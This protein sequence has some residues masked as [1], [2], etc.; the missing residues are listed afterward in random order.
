MYSH[1]HSPVVHRRHEPPAAATVDFLEE[2]AEP[3]VVATA[4][5]KLHGKKKW[6]N[7]RK[8]SKLDKWRRDKKWE[9]KTPKEVEPKYKN[10]RYRATVT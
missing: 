3:V 10:N 5:R 2:D 9:G 7:N 8:W 1:V 4:S 6:K